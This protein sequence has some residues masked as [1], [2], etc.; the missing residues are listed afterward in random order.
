M[1]VLDLVSFLT[2]CLADGASVLW[3]SKTIK[4]KILCLTLVQPSISW[5]FAFR[6]PASVLWMLPNLS[7]YLEINYKGGYRQWWKPLGELGFLISWI[8]GRCM[9]NGLVCLE[10]IRG[11]DLGCVH[12]TLA[13]IYLTYILL[14]HYPLI[15]ALCW[16]SW[17]TVRHIKS[18][19]ILS[20]NFWYRS[21]MNTLIL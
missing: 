14:W 1:L 19:S 20:F 10:D 16:N 9:F 3:R 12:L 13:F 4:R 21:I 5:L 8:S 17:L 2:G 7:F 11:V 18:S 15:I 6:R